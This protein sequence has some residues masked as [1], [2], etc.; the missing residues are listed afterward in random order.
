MENKRSSTLSTACKHFFSTDVLESHAEV[1]TVRAI[2][3]LKLQ[4]FG[5]LMQRTES[6]EKS[7]M[8]GNIEGRRRRG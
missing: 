7:P 5:H 6:L 1:L 4:S 8:L 3:H 2:L